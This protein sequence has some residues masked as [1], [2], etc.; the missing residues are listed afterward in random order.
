[1]KVAKE[2]FDPEKSGAIFEGMRV[3]L[4]TT[5]SELLLGQVLNSHPG[6]LSTRLAKMGLELSRQTAVP[7]GR[8]AGRA[9]P[10]RLWVGGG[11]GGGWG[12]RGP[13]AG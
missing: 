8:E 1:M 3:E 2:L 4:I 13:G 11:W 10:G 6:Y 9:P 7:D 12:G 5:G